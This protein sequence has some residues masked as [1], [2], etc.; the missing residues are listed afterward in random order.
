MSF[1][2]RISFEILQFNFFRRRTIRK[3]S[4]FKSVIINGRC[5]VNGKCSFNCFTFRKPNFQELICTFVIAP[6]VELSA[7]FKPCMVP[8]KTYFRPTY[9]S[10]SSFE[11][12]WTYFSPLELPTILTCIFLRPLLDLNIRIFF[13]YLNKT[14]STST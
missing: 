3:R 12:R 7:L 2:L 13:M 1:T 4:D 11:L 9:P 8:N 14:S 5:R 6:R 10:V